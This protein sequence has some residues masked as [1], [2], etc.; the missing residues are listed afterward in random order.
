MTSMR[1][2]P[3]DL[4]SYGHGFVVTIY[5]S[6]VQNASSSTSEK[7]NCYYYYYYYYYYYSAF[8]VIQL[9]INF[10]ITFTAS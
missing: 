1:V 6:V 7:T 3:L 2:Y 9:A 4:I 8:A 10:Q 5:M